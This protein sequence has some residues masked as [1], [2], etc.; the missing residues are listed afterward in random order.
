MPRKLYVLSALVL[1]SIVISIAGVSAD[2]ATEESGNVSIARTANQ[3][4]QTVT[5]S[6]NSAPTHENTTL[7]D[8]LADSIKAGERS[9]N[10]LIYA[11]IVSILF[12]QATILLFVIR[13]RKQR[14]FI[15][16][17]K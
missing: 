6:I 10:R 12:M 5:P 15:L 17:K 7:W 2:S 8:R 11:G 13:C 16:N 3:S 1:F 14:T 4:N 9:Q